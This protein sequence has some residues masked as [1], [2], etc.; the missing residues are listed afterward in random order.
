MLG[1]NRV[2]FRVVLDAHHPLQHVSV[3]ETVVRWA[4]VRSSTGQYTRR[5]FVSARIRLGTM[6]KEIE[7][8]LVSREEMTY[9]M[10]LGRQALAKEFLVDVSRRHVLS[11][12]KPAKG[13]KKS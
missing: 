4:R 3:T 13:R 11:R 12:R 6:E 8:S 1:D 9:R 7:L 5:C 10:L 2:R